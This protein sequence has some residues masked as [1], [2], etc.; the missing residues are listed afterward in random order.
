MFLRCGYCWQLREIKVQIV[1]KEAI[2]RALLLNA[3]N[4]SDLEVQYRLLTG[5]INLINRNLEIDSDEFELLVEDGL[6][7]KLISVRKAKRLLEQTGA[8]CF[9]DGRWVFSKD[10][11]L[12]GEPIDWE[13]FTALFIRK[14]AASSTVAAGNDP[15]RDAILRGINWNISMTLFAIK[16]G[17]IEGQPA[18]YVCEEDGDRPIGYK[19]AGTATSDSLTMLCQA[20]DYLVD[21]G[22]SPGEIADCIGFLVEKTLECRCAAPD[23]DKGGFFPLEDQPDST[24]PTVDA[25]CLAIM[26]LCSFYESC[27]AI[28]DRLSISLNA[29]N[30]KVE[31]AVLDGLAFLFRMQNPDGSF[32]IYNY[33]D[34]QTATPNENCT[35]MALSTMGV[36]KGSGI[37]DSTGCE[38]LYPTCSKVIA[39]AYT[40]LCNHTAEADGYRIWAPYFGGQARDYEIADVL[41]SGARVCRSLIP[42]WWQMEEER[43]NIL[44][45]C[46]DIL[47]FWQENED[48]AAK[49]TGRYRF[50]TPTDSGFSTGEYF[51]ASHPDMLAAFTVLQAYNLFGMALTKDQWAVIDRAIQHTLSLQ[52]EHG[53]WDNPLAKKTPF[54]AVTLAAL[55]LLQEYHNAKGLKV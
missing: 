37:F 46:H 42:V 15:V 23:W 49:K 55:E 8:F 18:F 16:A 20:S 51:W 10:L 38:H 44:S 35:R 2:L 7:G 52:H 33:E 3:G 19:V 21:C 4:G 32:G 43:D 11:T 13:R 53:H 47:R 48:N 26:A 36:C 6:S 17:D 25:T 54:C 40:Y 45:Y 31:K 12:Y 1:M 27:K 41:V 30:E 28:E 14:E 22:K 24:H 34:G 29:D 5:M 50:T 9:S 39:A